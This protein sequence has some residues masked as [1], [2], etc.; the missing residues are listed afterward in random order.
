MKQ[1]KKKAPLPM[2]IVIAAAIL[3]TFSVLFVVP[4]TIARYV[5]VA[6]AEAQARMAGFDIDVVEIGF[7]G[8]QM[9][10]FTRSSPQSESLF[11]IEAV[12]NSEVTVRARLRFYNVLANNGSNT[13]APANFQWWNNNH[14]RALPAVASMFNAGT[15][16]TSRTTDTLPHPRIG[17]IRTADT[18]GVFFDATDRQFYATG[19]LGTILEGAV[20]QP[21]EAIRFY[22]SILP[23]MDGPH[24]INN[25]RNHHDFS[26]NRRTPHDNSGD[27]RYNAV[28]RINFDIIATQVD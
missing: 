11:F 5:S 28:S 25:I 10:Y 6:Q 1:S 4:N 20:M 2:P 27:A 23:E 14:R 17:R 9:L 15:P 19:T 18:S 26:G 24:T 12:N 13:V 22:F 3:L 7:G 21:G 16:P 8:S